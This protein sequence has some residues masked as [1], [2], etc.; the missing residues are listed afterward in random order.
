MSAAETEIGQLS[1]REQE[2]LH[3][4]TAVTGQEPS[5]AIALLRR[6]QWNVQIAI[7]KFFDGEGPDPVEEARAALN[8]PPPR[9]TRHTQNLMS[10]DLSARFS[11]AARA[12]EPV[13][14]VET[15]PE[16]QGVYR[17][18]FLI[19]LLFTPFNLLYRLLYSSF[20]LFGSLFPFLPRL[21]NVTANP[22]LQGGRRNTNGRRTLGP[23]D[24]AARFIREFEEEY[25][26]NSFPFLENGYNMALDKA[27]RDLKFLL[28]VLLSPEHDDTSSWVRETL[29][30]REVT[31][32]ITSSQGD[33][34]VWGGNVQDSET[35]QVA[36]S[37]RCSK[38]PFAAVIVHTPNV[39]STAMSV[40]SRIAGNTTP[41]E[42]LAKLRGAITQNKEALDRIRASRAEQQ[43]SRSLR[44]QQD[45]AYE[46]SL[47]IDR[48]R[49]RQRR[50]AEAAR[51]REEQAA[52]E[53]QAA[54]E[55]RQRDLQQWKQWRAQSIAAEPGPAVGDAVR[56]S[57][58]LPS[59]ERVIR[60]F[61]P[62]AA[63]EE[64]YAF[65][66]CYEVLQAQPDVSSEKPEGFEHQYRFRLVSP[67]PRVVYE[68]EAGGTIADKVGRGGNLLVEPIDEESEEE[69]EEK[70]EEEEV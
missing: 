31:E 14:R 27:H 23:K 54:E 1:E 70:E 57:I 37:L 43:A 16:D 7:S 29:L 12:V 25:G 42:F 38:F 66:E 8:S 3:T 22:A 67:M 9:P 47:A 61:P 20:Q 63:L 65:V 30:S 44:E 64:L 19:A 68:L 59:G 60:M 24:T 4:Y 40:V 48:E 10:E 39:S 53:R 45:S 15:Q 49:A 36:N 11:P 58:R 52:A 46:R 50:E 34:L 32:Y 35:Y 41:T 6:S 69:E 5:E 55:K 51:Q 18:S 2:A 62:G 28:V 17:P 33:L 26:P 21:L 56:I 13:R